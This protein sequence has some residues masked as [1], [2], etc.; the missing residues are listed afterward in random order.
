MRVTEIG[1]DR[2]VCSWGVQSLLL[3]GTQEVAVRRGENGQRPAHRPEGV[4]PGEEGEDS[5]SEGN[6]DAELC[7]WELRV[8]TH[9]VPPLRKEGS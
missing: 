8:T 4:Q 7:H 9:P 6:S 2:F 5:P 3:L 1:L